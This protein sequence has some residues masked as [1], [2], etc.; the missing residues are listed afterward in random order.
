MKKRVFKEPPVWNI[1]A[2]KHYAVA[3]E[4]CR[5]NNDMPR[6]IKALH[7]LY[8][9][10]KKE[11]RKSIRQ[12]MG[13]VGITATHVTAFMFDDQSDKYLGKTFPSMLKL[14][15]AIY[16]ELLSNFNYSIK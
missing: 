7:E 6:T 5:A 15:G 13:G 4:L 16:H 9:S 10:N 14:R 11:I 3:L 12:Y 2:I 8:C 1:K